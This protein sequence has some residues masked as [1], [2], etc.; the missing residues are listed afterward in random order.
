MYNGETPSE[1][2]ANSTA[3][4][5]LADQL[6]YTRYWFAEHHNTKYQMSSAPDL[7]SAHTAVHTKR[8]RIGAGGIMLP[9]HSPLKV[10]ENFS[11]LEALHPERI[12]LGIGRAPGTDQMTA[13]ALRRFEEAVTKDHFPEQLNQL[14][15]FYSRSFPVDHPF[16]QI[17]PTPVEAIPALFMLGSSQG[18]MQF[19][20]NNGLGFV[21][22][23]HISPDL[24]VPVLRT[25]RE[26]FKPSVF[27]SA[28]KSTLSTIVIRAETDE[29]A[30][31]LAR[32]VD[33]Q[34]ARRG[35][36]TFNPPPP[37]LDHERSHMYSPAEQAGY[38]AHKGRIII[39]SVKKVEERLRTLAAEAMVYEI[40]ILNMLTDKDTRHQSFSLL[41]D[42]FELTASH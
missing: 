18:G 27:L 23:A 20:I 31:D 7:L 41:A 25:Y 12:D 8:I 35:T 1:T 30:R 2:L 28:A 22:A 14:L 15:S 34:W 11:M 29:E 36:V 40:M 4:V 24:A 38:Q 3:L 16:S 21:F 19:A 5:Q 13:Y 9:N 42:A 32:P 10:V 37:T 17:T 33:L 39:G 6:G 26:N